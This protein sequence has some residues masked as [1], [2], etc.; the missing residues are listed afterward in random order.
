MIDDNDPLFDQEV[1][2]DG[3]QTGCFSDGVLVCCGGRQLVA[4]RG[5][6][7]AP[8]AAQALGLTPIQSLV[9]YTIPSKEEAAQCTIRPEKENN[10][11]AWVVRNRQG[12]ILR[13]FA[14]TNADNIVDSG[15]TT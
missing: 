8:T 12:E 14:D 15:A 2:R 6:A 5:A 1:P 11:T 7:E 3:L 4:N 13:R 10:A 9:E